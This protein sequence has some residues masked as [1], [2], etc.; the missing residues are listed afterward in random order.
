MTPS[1]ERISSL[2]K[3]AVAYIRELEE[4]TQRAEATIPWTE[5]G[6]EWFTLFAAPFATPPK[7]LFTCSE[8]G[9]HQVCSLDAKDRVFIGRAKK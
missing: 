2:P 1:R 9:T 5:P 7:A 6:M 8:S 4:R 3:W